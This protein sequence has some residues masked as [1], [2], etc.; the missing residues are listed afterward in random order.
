MVKPGTGRRQRVNSD[1]HMT[2]GSPACR[3]CQ[4]T[5]PTDEIQGLCAVLDEQ[6]LAQQH[7]DEMGLLLL[8]YPQLS[9]CQGD[10]AKL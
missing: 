7:L 8:F 2:A 1:L 5:V 3:S 4:T 6:A 9:G 10:L